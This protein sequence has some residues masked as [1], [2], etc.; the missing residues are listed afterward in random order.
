MVLAFAF[1]LMLRKGISELNYKNQENNHVSPDF[2]SVR[3]QHSLAV[4]WRNFYNFLC[5][6]SSPE[7]SKIFTVNSL[8]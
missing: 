4:I 6:E 1:L 3:G 5:V 7:P 8:A 2:C